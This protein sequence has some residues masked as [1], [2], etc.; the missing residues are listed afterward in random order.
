MYH[1]NL[2]ILYYFHPIVFYILYYIGERLLLSSMRV[3]HSATMRQMFT[4]VIMAFSM[5]GM[6][7][8]S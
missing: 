1:Y 7:R 2:Y 5:L 6:G 3:F 8:N 4:T